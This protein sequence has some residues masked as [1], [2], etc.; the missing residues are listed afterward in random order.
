MRNP[1]ILIGESDD[2]TLRD[3]AS[4]LE[5][6]G[7]DVATAQDG[8]AAIREARRYQPDLALLD[9]SLPVIDGVAAGDRIHQELGIPVVFL[10]F[11][12]DPVAERARRYSSY[13]YLE[14][15]FSQRELGTAIELALYRHRMERVLTS[16][17]Q[18]FRLLFDQNPAGVVLESADGR[19][20]E[21]NAALAAMLG[22]PSPDALRQQP[23]SAL[24]LDPLED[25]ERR[26]RVAAGEAVS[27]EEVRLRHRDGRPVWA[28][29]NAVL[30][31][32][33]STG[34][35]Q[36]LRT[37][38]DITERKQIE[39]GLERLAY[40]DPLTGLPNRRL[41]ALRA[42]QTLAEA[43]RRGESAAL[44]F[45]DQVGFT[46]GNDQLGHLAGDELLVQ[47]ARRLDQCLRQSDA[48][49][50]VGGDEFMVLLSGVEDEPA[51]VRA[52]QRILR[53]LSMPFPLDS[54]E[55][56]VH[57]RAG[58]ATYPEPAHTFDGLVELADR[59]LLKARSAE[60]PAL[61]LEG[62]AERQR[63]SA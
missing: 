41:L 60:V 12:D 19:I 31:P 24:F 23:A 44:M 51:A 32:D 59:A 39:Q 34:R 30:V 61:V 37:L 21:C 13:G 55:V 16:S 42:E 27:N 58:L 52:A 4:S 57:A 43:D 33:P 6:L 17:E 35:G 38:L 14:K 1:R 9:V 3:L 28:V 18:R 25:L 20:I 56:Q 36:I 29:D 11:A 7:Y 50:R 15:P 53:A 5:A 63:E 45:I 10:A 46:R 47:V 40:R 62:I 54:G 8:P 26:H 22:F 49:A 2:G 48:A